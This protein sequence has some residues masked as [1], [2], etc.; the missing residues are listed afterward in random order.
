M[1]LYFDLSGFCWKNNWK[2]IIGCKSLSQGLA[3]GQTSVMII[4]VLVNTGA[5][6]GASIWF[7][8]LFWVGITRALRNKLNY[9]IFSME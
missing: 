1:C 7:I 4:G 6:Y 5:K 3:S 2:E 9:S 8:H